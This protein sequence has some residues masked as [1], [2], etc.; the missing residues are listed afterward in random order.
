M[1]ATATDDPEPHDSLHVT[2][3]WINGN[4]VNYSAQDRELALAGPCGTDVA[5]K[6]YDECSFSHGYR[7]VAEFH[8]ADR[9]WQFQWTEAGILLIPAL[10]LGGVAI[11]RTLQPRI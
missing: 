5:T 8:P 9:F 4:G 3:Y 6:K 10:A 1:Q 7:Q 2:S 11:R